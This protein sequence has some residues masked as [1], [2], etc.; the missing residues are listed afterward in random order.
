MQ[1]NLQVTGLAISQ[2]SLLLREMWLGVQSS[3]PSYG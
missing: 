3:I 1:I 2:S